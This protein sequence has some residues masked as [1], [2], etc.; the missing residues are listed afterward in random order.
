MLANQIIVSAQVIK[1]S[2]VSLANV[3]GCCYVC[4]EVL[5]LRSYCTIHYN[6]SSRTRKL[7]A[8]L[9]KYQRRS[10]FAKG[11]RSAT[12]TSFNRIIPSI[13]LYWWPGHV[14]ANQQF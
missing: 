8:D 10:L 3:S 9:Y 2:I 5:E 1:P 4:D 13:V 6:P 11:N 7:I 14:T 12:S